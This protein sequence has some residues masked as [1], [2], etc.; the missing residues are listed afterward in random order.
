MFGMSSAPQDFLAFKR[1]AHI[2][3]RCNT[4]SGIGMCVDDAHDSSFWVPRDASCEKDW[5][6]MELNL[7][8]LSLGTVVVFP[9]ILS[10]LVCRLCLIKRAK[11]S[12]A[13]PSGMLKGFGCKTYYVHC[14]TWRAGRPSGCGV[15]NFVSS[16]C[17]LAELSVVWSKGCGA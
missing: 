7:F 5:K 13:I 10:C 1:S 14:A 16:L 3:S 9:S 6:N 11:I 2:L 8:A 15:Q 17:V 12:G 4:T